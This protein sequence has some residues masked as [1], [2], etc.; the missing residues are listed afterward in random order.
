[1]TKSPASI[2]PLLVQACFP[3]AFSCF[4]FS[5]RLSLDPSHSLFTHTLYP[6]TMRGFAL[7]ALA[8]LSFGIF[9]FA[10]PVPMPGGGSL[11]D[12]DVDANV[13]VRVRDILK[14]DVNADVDVRARNLVSVDADVTADVRVRDSNDQCLDGIIS[15]VISD[16]GNVIDEIGGF[17]R[18]EAII[19]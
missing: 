13:D 19:L 15:G 18:L 11:V 17:F 16:V 14:A 7:S 5:L 4:Q 8:F 3:S 6:S 1:M 2:N 12:V 10:A 9:A